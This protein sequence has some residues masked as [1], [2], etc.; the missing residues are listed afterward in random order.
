MTALFHTSLILN[1]MPNIKEIH[2]LPNDLAVKLTILKSMMYCGVLWGL[3]HEGWAMMRDHDET[4]FPFW[5]NSSHATNYAS[6]HWPNYRPRKIT[7]EDF[8]QSLIP[9]LRRFNVTPVLVR[10]SGKQIKLTI[11]QMR[12]F[13]FAEQGL[14]FA[15]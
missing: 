13:F 8:E 4:L 5:L 3:F 1:K 2:P 15:S 6:K 7:P 10:G 9:I 14:Y 11:G 12:H